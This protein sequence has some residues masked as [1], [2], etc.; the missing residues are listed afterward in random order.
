MDTNPVNLILLFWVLTNNLDF[1]VWLSTPSDIV[2]LGK[3]QQN[4]V[5]GLSI[6]AQDG[7]IKLHS[8]LPKL[9]S[10]AIVYQ[11]II[12]CHHRFVQK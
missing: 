1:L 10:V 4:V 11:T 3:H 5:G 8:F 9:I 12:V 2:V 6:Y 7:M